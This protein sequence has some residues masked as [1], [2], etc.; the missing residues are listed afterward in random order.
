MFCCPGK[1]NRQE[2]EQ[3]KFITGELRKERRAREKEMKL[4]LL[5]INQ[6]FYFFIPFIS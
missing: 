4:L 5:G 6:F 2:Y 1:V 3:N